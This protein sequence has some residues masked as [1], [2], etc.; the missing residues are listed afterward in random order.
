MRVPIRNRAHMESAER[1]LEWVAPEEIDQ[2]L[3]KTVTLGFSI[4]HEDAISGAL[5]L[6][7]FG[8]AT[9]KISQALEERIGSLVTKRR[10]QVVNGIV[11]TTSVYP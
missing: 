3:L 8:R 10:L 11:T 1:K 6:L 4:S 2:A 7:G 9:A 5:D